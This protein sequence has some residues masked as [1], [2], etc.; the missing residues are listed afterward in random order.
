MPQLFSNNG[1]ALL[2]QDLL[3]GDLLAVVDADF[4]TRFPLPSG[5]TDFF[6]AVLDDGAGALEVVKCTLRNGDS[7]VIE[8]AQE[9]TVAQDFFRGARIGCRISAGTMAGFM[10][11]DQALFSGT[12]NLNGNALINGEILGVPQRGETGDTSNEIVVPP[13]SRS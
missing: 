3:A 8:R 7:M 11:P 12:A 10:E 5:P 4:G 6:I 1:S 9:G 2:A 13:L